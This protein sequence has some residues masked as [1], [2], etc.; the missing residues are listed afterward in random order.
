MKVRPG[1]AIATVT[2]QLTVKDNKYSL[3]VLDEAQVAAG[4]GGGR[5]RNRSG[6]PT[7]ANFP[8]SKQKPAN[9]LYGKLNVN[10]FVQKLSAKGITDAKVESSPNGSCIIHL[11][12]EETLIQIDD[13]ETHVVCDQIEGTP[14]SERERLRET[15]K[16]TILSCVAKF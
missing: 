6:T 14:A 1:V 2:G 16:Q 3:N 8:L 13:N 7:V 4:P 12:R 10:E 11:L 15:L 9:Y 5:K